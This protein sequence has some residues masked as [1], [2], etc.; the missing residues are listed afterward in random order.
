MR[1]RI[2]RNFIQDPLYAL[3]TIQ[4]V[5]LIL[6]WLRKS[7]THRWKLSSKTETVKYQRYTQIRSQ[8]SI[9]LYILHNT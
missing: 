6:A 9:D 5:Y 3:N 1:R 4:A 2:A 7:E 8:S